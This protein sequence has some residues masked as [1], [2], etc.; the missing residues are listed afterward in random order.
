MAVYVMV[1][2]CVALLF[3]FVLIVYVIFVL[4]DGCIIRQCRYGP[5]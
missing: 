1:G 3:L 5:R 2:V 4:G